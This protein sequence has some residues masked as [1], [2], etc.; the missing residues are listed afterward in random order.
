[1]LIPITNPADARLADYRNVPDPELIARDG[2]FVAEGRL[3]VAR[4]L[5][6][7]RFQTRSVMATR[8]ALASLRSAS[9]T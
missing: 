5:G 7:S 6:S 9:C 8:P 1:M 4:L 3:V 2:I